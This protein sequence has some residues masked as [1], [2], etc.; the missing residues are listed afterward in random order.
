MDTDFL[1]LFPKRREIHRQMDEFLGM[2]DG[3]IQN[4]KTALKAGTQND[5]LEENEKDLLNLMIE[6]GE[7]GEGILTDRELK[8]CNIIK[9]NS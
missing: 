4:K 3:V 9:L 2:L 6:S 1:W 5:A 8:V 7:K